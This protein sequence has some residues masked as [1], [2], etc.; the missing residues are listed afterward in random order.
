MTKIRNLVILLVFG[1]IFLI[2]GLSSEPSS[3]SQEAVRPQKPLQYEVRVTVKLIQ[4]IVT[5]KKG[6]P[7]TDLR[8]EDF[9]LTDNGQEMK[10]TEFEKHVLSIP[11]AE[12]PA[13]ERVAATRFPLRAFSTANFF[14]SSISPTTIPPASAKWGK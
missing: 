7:V 14:S 1:S 5:T 12:K 4:V 10:L 2:A 13:E 3:S 6:N 11:S 8:K 9:V